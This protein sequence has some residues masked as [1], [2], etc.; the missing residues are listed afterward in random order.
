MGYTVKLESLNKDKLDR[1]L[2][3][4]VFCADESKVTTYTKGYN[5]LSINEI[6]SKKLLVYDED[7]RNL[8]VE[9]ELNKII[10]NSVEPLLIKDFEMLFNPEYQIDVLK[11]FIMAN[12][13][14]KIS[15]LWSGRYEEGKLLFAEPGY[16]DYKSYNVSDYDISCII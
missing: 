4:I 11:L 13:K 5:I 7:K 1:L 8:I 10:E 3:P 9:D 15:V 16:I 6:L 12:R 14:N 2:A